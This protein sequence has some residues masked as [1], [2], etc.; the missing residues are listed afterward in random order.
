M[1]EVDS[2]EDNNA[3]VMAPWLASDTKRMYLP[4]VPDSTLAG[5]G[6]HP[7]RRF[8]ISASGTSRSSV[9]LTACVEWS[10]LV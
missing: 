3:P 2:I 6:V 5:R 10:L 1:C 9:F 4:N 8:S 7:C